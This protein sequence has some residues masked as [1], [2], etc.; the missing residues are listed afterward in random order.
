MH[1]VCEC[2]LHAAC[3]SLD[4]DIVKHAMKT[5]K[6]NVIEC[7]LVIAHTFQ[8]ISFGIARG[9]H[10]MFI[11]YNLYGFYHLLELIGLAQTCL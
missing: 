10:V 11:C 5:H 8:I 9:M 6:A 3:Y 4:I 7:E 2:L 1:N